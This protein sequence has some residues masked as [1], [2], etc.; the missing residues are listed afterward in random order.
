MK[1]RTL[2]SFLILISLALYFYNNFFTSKMLKGIYIN[3]NYENSIFGGSAL[4]TLIIFGNNQFDSKYWGSG[5]F[6]LSY[7]LRGTTIN[8]H[9]NNSLTTSVYRSWFSN[10][11]IMIMKDLDTYY[12]RQ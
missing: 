4:D 3:K 2:I 6:D 9:S 1:L 11:R 8:M 10:P 5:R 12:E 7:S